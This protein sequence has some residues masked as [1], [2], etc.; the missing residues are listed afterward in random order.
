MLPQGSPAREQL[1]NDSIRPWSLCSLLNTIG[2]SAETVITKIPLWGPTPGHQRS[3]QIPVFSRSHYSL[4][5][6]IR[7]DLVAH[8]VWL[9]AGGHPGVLLEGAAGVIIRVR[10]ALVDVTP[11]GCLASNTRHQGLQLDLAGHPASHVGFGF[12]EMK[13]RI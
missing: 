12:S 5:D 1:A 6:L 8:L 2:K 3:S 9:E 11:G 4:T 13:S 7:S 10:V